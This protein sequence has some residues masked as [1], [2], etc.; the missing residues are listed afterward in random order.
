MHPCSLT[1]HTV[2]P[3][4]RHQPAVLPPFQL[5]Q[6]A[7]M[8]KAAA[9]QGSCG[10]KR[11]GRPPLISKDSKEDSAAARQRLAAYLQQHGGISK[12]DAAELAGKL[13][14]KLGAAADQ[15]VPGPLQWFVGRGM[16]P[17]KAAKVVMRICESPS[18]DASKLRH[19]PTWQPV[20][21]ANWQLADSYLAAYQQRC[22]ETKQKPRKGSKSMAAMLSSMPS[23][24]KMLPVRDLP[25]KLAALQQGQLGLSVAD[26]GNLV[27]AGAKLGST[28]ATI[29]SAIQLLVRFAGSMEAA[30]GMLRVAAP[31][32]S[33]S[34]V[35]LDSK[36]AALQAAWAGVLQPE[37]LRQLVLRSALV[38]NCS[39]H[40][41]GETAAVLRSWFPQ[42][43][44]LLAI[45]QSAPQLLAAS[46]TT[47]QDNER[48]FTGPPL[49]LS[50]QQFLEL[51]RASPKA[52][53]VKITGASTQHKLAFLTQVG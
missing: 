16:Q 23:R 41:Y 25:S 19:W 30:L 15:L 48:W 38:L 14:A 31:L 9:A 42:P 12:A 45:L 21:E 3:A 34:A 50:R 6:A 52:F 10:S 4:R 29:A 17:L 13:S 5:L 37:Q 32:L 39:E 49:S 8:S 28:P 36:V 44:E 2:L 33:F 46:A 43:S 27:A 53:E 24:Y 40:R 51:V 20:F 18:G 11:R 47:L 7:G 26:V 35:T 22:R 1:N